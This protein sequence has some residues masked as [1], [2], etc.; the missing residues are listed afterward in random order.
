MSSFFSLRASLRLWL[1]LHHLQLL[2]VAPRLLLDVPDPLF[3]VLLESSHHRITDQTRWTLHLIKIHEGLVVKRVLMRIDDPLVVI[4]LWSLVIWR[5]MYLPQL[6]CGTRIDEQK[7]HSRPALTPTQSD[8]REVLSNRSSSSCGQGHSHQ[9]QHGG[10]WSGHTISFSPLKS[11]SESPRS[12]NT[13]SK[14]LVTSSEQLFLWF[15]HPSTEDWAYSQKIWAILYYVFYKLGI[16]YP[17]LWRL[18]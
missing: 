9:G 17:S 12:E 15:H 7:D 11:A 18:L 2:L 10:R 3:V 16:I 5:I 1:R 8:L 6:C 13:T 14:W 4:S